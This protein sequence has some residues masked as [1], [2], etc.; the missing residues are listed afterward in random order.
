ML[1]LLMLRAV[2]GLWGGALVGVVVLAVLAVLGVL[3]VLVVVCVGVGSL[4]TALIALMVA[5]TLTGVL[6]LCPRR[7]LLG[8]L[9]LL[10]R[11]GVGLVG[12][13]CALPTFLATAPAFLG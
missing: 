6:L 9:G 13:W 3:G 1:L 10:G 7:L 5:L 8:G 12:C 2:W 4:V 11:V